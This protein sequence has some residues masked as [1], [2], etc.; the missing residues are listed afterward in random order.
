MFH[1]PEVPF[2]DLD[3]FLLASAVTILGV[4]FLFGRI[5]SEVC[6]RTCDFCGKRVLPHEHA[7]HVT[8]CALK[9][10]LLRELRR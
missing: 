6:R 4:I 9:V 10:M 7:H 3:S 1:L 2:N 8:V 5:R